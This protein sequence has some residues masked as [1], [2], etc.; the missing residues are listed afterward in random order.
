VGYDFGVKTPEGI[1]IFADAETVKQK[2]K[3]AI[4]GFAAL[5]VEAPLDHAPAFASSIVTKVDTRVW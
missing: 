3:K 1:A 5:T 4:K 2:F